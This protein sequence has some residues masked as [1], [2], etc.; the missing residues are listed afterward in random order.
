M[1]PP[2][3]LLNSHCNGHKG[4]RVPNWKRWGASS[5]YLFRLTQWGKFYLFHKHLLGTYRNIAENIFKQIPLL[6]STQFPGGRQTFSPKD[7]LLST[8][9]STLSKGTHFY[10]SSS[11]SHG[12]WGG[13][14]GRASQRKWGSICT[15]Q[16]EEDFMD[17]EE[18]KE[19]H[20][21]GTEWLVWLKQSEEGSGGNSGPEHVALR[22][23][24]LFPF[25][26]FSSSLLSISTESS[27]FQGF[28][29]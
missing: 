3:I 23:Q 7:P 6:L 12:T 10:E 15:L 27:A 16:N 29:F 5:V 13:V 20:M 14:Q 11:K 25:R 19:Q 21:R 17:Q 28:S 4:Q 8:E 2:T 24:G 26:P 1:E 9:M 22:Q 18:K